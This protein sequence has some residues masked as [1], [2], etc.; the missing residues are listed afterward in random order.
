M[1]PT[2]GTVQNNK[3]L[4][5]ITG[6]PLVA[7]V[8]K[9]TRSDGL[10]TPL[11]NIQVTWQLDSG[12]EFVDGAGNSFIPQ[13][14]DAFGNTTVYWRLGPTNLTQNAVVAIDTNAL[15]R[16]LN[17]SDNRDFQFASYI[18]NALP[19]V[20]VP[21]PSP[22]VVEI[23]DIV[24]P[25]VIS[26]IQPEPPEPLAPQPIKLTGKIYTTV[27]PTAEIRDGKLGIPGLAGSA[28][29]IGF[30]TD[31]SGIYNVDNISQEQFMAGIVVTTS[32]GYFHLQL[33]WTVNVGYTSSIIS[34]FNTPVGKNGTIEHNISLGI[35]DSIQGTDIT[36]SGNNAK[37]LTGTIPDNTLFNGVVENSFIGG[38]SKFD[39]PV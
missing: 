12:G 38:V 19:P 15:I 32:P 6:E 30:V 29:G 27:P 14:T 8:Y 1:Y 39:Q 16:S 34:A 25:P 31:Q 37:S 20:P 2:A 9:Y 36:I 24:K 3:V 4:T 28:G 35:P 17:V 10:L 21:S 26:D 5:A 7:T 22:I 33:G 23:K 13:V 18:A 11:P